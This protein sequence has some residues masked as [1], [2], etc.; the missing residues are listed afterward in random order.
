MSIKAL[1][2]QFA[3]QTAGTKTRGAFGIIAACFSQ[4][5]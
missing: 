5:A 1:N 4:L 2:S 3:A